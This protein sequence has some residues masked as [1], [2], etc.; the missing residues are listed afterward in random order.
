[1]TCISLKSNPRAEQDCDCPLFPYSDGVT[2]SAVSTATIKAVSVSASVAVGASGTTGV[3]LCQNS[4]E[5]DVSKD[6]KT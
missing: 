2:L 6:Q 4:V 1:M 3:A 5:I